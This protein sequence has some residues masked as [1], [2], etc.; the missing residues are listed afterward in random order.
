MSLIFYWFFGSR[1]DL[2]GR[3]SG[4]HQ[5]KIPLSDK[6]IEFLQ[7]VD[8]LSFSETETSRFRIE[9]IISLS[10]DLFGDTSELLSDFPVDFL[11]FFNLSFPFIL[12]YSLIEKRI[13]SIWDPA[14]SFW[15]YRVQVDYQTLAYQS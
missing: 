1:L 11:T 9:R 14:G 7:F 3:D 12:Y 6:K 2:N 13:V 10:A 4:Q 8:P 5:F 15:D